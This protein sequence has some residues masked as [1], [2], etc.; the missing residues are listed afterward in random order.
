MSVFD[1]VKIS[2]NGQDYTIKAGNVMQ[3]IEVIEDYITL[4]DLQSAP[5]LTKLS[6]AYAAAINFAG[7]NATQE[8]VYAS[9]FRDKISAQ[10]IVSGL[11]MMMIQ[12]EHLRDNGAGA[13]KKSKV[14]SD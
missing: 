12:P 1:D 13:E 10:S 8:D 9:F 2:F 7:G 11:L 4:T 14:K 5:K 3:L 6:A